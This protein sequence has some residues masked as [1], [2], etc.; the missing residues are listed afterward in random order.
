M[1]WAIIENMS[2]RKLVMLGTVMLVCQVLCFLVGAIWAPAPNNSDQFLA[3]KCHDT[4][5]E[6][7]SGARWFQPRGKNRCHNIDRIDEDVALQSKAENVV[8]AVQMPFSRM[9]SQLDYSRWQQNLLGILAADIEY[10]KEYDLEEEVVVILEAKL[11]YKNKGDND[12][13]WKEYARSVALRKLDCILDEDK[14]REGNYYNCSNIPLFYLGS[15]HHDYYLLNIK[16]TIMNNN[17]STLVINNQLV[18]HVDLWLNV[19]N[20]NGGFTLMWVTFKSIFFLV[21]IV[22]LVWFWRRV[23]MLS[24]TPSLLQKMLILLGAALTFLNIPFEYLSLAYEMPW[25]HLLT[26]SQQWVFYTSLLLFWLIFTRENMKDYTNVEK[27]ADQH[28]YWKNCALVLFGCLCLFVFDMVKRGI[29]LQNPFYSIWMMDFGTN[30]V[31]GFRILSGILAVLYLLLLCY[32]IRKM[33][34]MKHS[35]TNTYDHL[36]PVSHTRFWRFELIMLVT[37]LK[38]TLTLNGFIIEQ[39]AEDA[40]KWNEHPPE[41][42]EYTSW[43]ITG[44]YGMWNIYVFTLLFLYAP[45]SKQWRYGANPGK[46]VEI[47]E[48]AEEAE[49]RNF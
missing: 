44:V 15:L 29:Q 8:Y 48:S 23:L 39:V 24:K 47:G 19:I 21:I 45:S 28:G 20:Q 36:S 1:S 3:T 18:K 49:N 17:N 14:R 6:D 12:K 2:S 7:L 22:E 25:L 46:E 13:E 26:T 34:K 4:Q 33:F 32:S 5:G 9:G 43:L 42:L 16:F 35:K 38:V 40:Y 10:Q 41:T 11:G 27:S 37:L 30:F 31:Q